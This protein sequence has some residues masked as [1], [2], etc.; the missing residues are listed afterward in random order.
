MSRKDSSFDYKKTLTLPQTSF[1]IKTNLEKVKEEVLKYWQEKNI[2]KKILEKNKKNQKGTFV[3]HDGPPYAN[4]NIHVGHVLNKVLKDIVI[5]YRLLLGYYTPF[6]PGWDCHGLPIEYAVIDK[7][8]LSKEKLTPIEV[9]QQCKDYALNFVD[10]QKKQFQD[11]GVFG[12]FESPYLTLDPRFEASE[13]ELFLNFFKKGLI[14]RQ[15]KPVFWCPYC[16]SALAEAE[17]EYQN[18]KSPSIFLKLPFADED[19]LKEYSGEKFL[20]VWTTTP[21]TLPGNVAFAINPKENY[22]VVLCKGEIYIFMEKRLKF[23]KRFLPEAK[24]LNKISPQT[25]LGK[26]IFHPFFDD[27]KSSIF[28]ADFV[29][30]KEGTGV[31]HIAPAH[32]LEDFLLAQKENLPLEKFVDEKGRFVS[33]IEELAHVFITEANEKIIEKLKNKGFLLALED[34]VHSYPHC[35]RCHN[36][37]IFRA[38]PQWFIKTGPIVEEA[39]KQLENVKFYPPQSKRRLISMLEERPDWCISRQRYWGVPIPSLVCKDCGEEFLDEKII[40][41]VIKVFKEESSDAWFQKSVEFFTENKVFCPKCKSGN[42]EKGENILDV[43]FDSGSSY[44]SVW[45]MFPFL[46]FPA[47]LYLEGSDQHR[48]W[49]QSSLL[50]HTGGLNKAPYKSIVSHGFCVDSFGEK[51]SK[52]KGN[53]IDPEQVK[54]IFGTEILRLWVALSDWRDDV[55]ISSPK[56]SKN[57]AP[58]LESFEQMYFKIRNT[59]RFMLANLYDFD[60]SLYKIE[61]VTNPIN[62]WILAKNQEVL[63]KVTENFEKYQFF[64]ATRALYNF[65]VEELSS[66]YFDVI[67]DKLYTWGKNSP[68]RREIQI[69]LYNLLFTLL[70]LIAPVLSFLAEEIVFYLPF[71]KEESVFLYSWPSI[72]KKLY[73][74]KILN[75]F[76]KLLNLRS[77]INEKL[78]EKRK[79]KEIS[80][81]LEARVILTVQEEDFELLLKYREIL[82]E[83]LIISDLVLEKGDVFGIEVQKTSFKKCQRCWKYLSS[84]GSNEKYPELCDHCIKVIEENDW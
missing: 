65:M 41:K 73:N 57:Q 22:I 9:R 15:E 32:G 14:F 35:W 24:I 31:V 75:D 83:F 46:S 44:Y 36:P 10:I 11:L 29:S 28:A 59:F 16:Q 55:R 68:E 78:E 64:K 77:K 50:I 58:I 51:M 7:T 17:V 21:W 62:L 2:Y 61:K 81:S 63:E 3:L 49:F 39:K 12:L 23:L 25:L 71:E 79:N 5:K 34:I 45:K 67:K 18:K 54:E 84:V 40:K 19:F 69:V 38:T 8:G 33:E 70:P 30:S 60:P 20:L 43:W 26:Q 37:I 42:L 74:K 72:N 82:S 56:F 76:G 66:I 47:D 52:S 80:S 6:V 4:G 27:K 1:P 13:M 53:V 48:G